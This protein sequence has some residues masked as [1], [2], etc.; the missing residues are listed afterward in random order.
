MRKNQVTAQPHRVVVVALPEVVAFDLSIAAEVFG[1]NQRYAFRL[2]TPGSRRVR[3]ST[4]FAVTG[5]VGLAALDGADTV[6][7]PGYRPPARPLPDR[8]LSGLR[9]AHE[10]GARVVSIC[11]GAFALAAAGLLDGRQATTHWCY[12]RELA[13]LHPKVSVVDNVLY[14]DQGDIATS[15]GVAAGIDLCLHLVRTDHGQKVATTLARE[16]VVAPFRGGS[17]A[18]YVERPLPASSREDL[19]DDGLGPTR[20]WAQQRLG[21]PLTLRD[22]A[23]HAGYSVRTFCRRFQAE[24]GTSPLRWLHEQRLALALHLLEETVLPID[25]IAATSGFGTAANFRIHLRRATGTT[26][27]AH[28]QAFRG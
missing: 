20:S 5:T 7:I 13:E 16:L 28:R 19:D 27:T 23:D 15:A 1:N 18:Q 10:R 2:C 26:P 12:T 8:V 21:D 6:I 4:G 17:Q 9:A 3:T 11:T 22:L 24:T 25:Q 14:V